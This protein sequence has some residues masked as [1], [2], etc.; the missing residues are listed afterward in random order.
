RPSDGKLV[1][2]Y[3]SLFNY[4]QAAPAIDGDDLVFGA[5]DTNLRCLDLGTGRLKWVWNNGKS[6]N[7]LGPGN[8][9]PV[10]SGERVYIVAPDRYMT[11]IDRATGRTL[12]RDN[13]HRYRE[14]LGRSED[15]SRVYAKTMDGELVAV[16]ATVPEFRE[17]WTIDMGL[18]Y[19]HAPCIV[20]EHD[21][22][23][24]AGSRRGIVT[25]IDP[26]TK[27]VLASLPLGVSEINGIDIDPT[28][29]DVYASLIEGTVFRISRR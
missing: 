5:W 14:S 1:W 6:A 24:Y 29:G 17:L 13:S 26:A 4:C 12:W 11:A 3:D 9:V 15:G 28:T 8:V 27:T 2:S 21:G 25:M 23:V 16:D 19:E 22:I 20:A 18:G 10:I 7:M